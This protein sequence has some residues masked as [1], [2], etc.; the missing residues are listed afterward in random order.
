MAIDFRLHENNG[1]RTED[2]Q[3]DIGAIS[4]DDPGLF[5]FFQPL[6]TGR[7]RQIDM[8]RQLR[9]GHSTIFLQDR[10]NFQVPLV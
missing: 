7:R 4:F 6:P 8:R 10:Q 5:Q 9:L 2:F 3:G 1:N